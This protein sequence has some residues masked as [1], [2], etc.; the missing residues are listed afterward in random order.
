MI[1]SQVSKGFGFFL[2]LSKIKRTQETDFVIF[3][4]KRNRTGKRILH[5]MENTRG[6]GSCQ[7]VKTPLRTMASTF[8]MAVNPAII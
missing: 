5:R 6:Q 7:P 1:L 2:Q 4:A 3:G 8:V